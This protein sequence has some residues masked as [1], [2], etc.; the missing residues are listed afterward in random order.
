MKLYYWCSALLSDTVMYYCPLLFAAML[1]H[2]TRRYT[3]AT[4]H[5]AILHYALLCIAKGF[6]TLQDDYATQNIAGTR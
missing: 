2:A 3:H 6:N 4:L 5:Y 1:N